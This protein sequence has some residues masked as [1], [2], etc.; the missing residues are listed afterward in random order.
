MFKNRKQ[1]LID[2]KA[3]RNENKTNKDETKL[4]VKE[5]I[6]HNEEQLPAIAYANQEI[7]IV[8]P[9]IEE[10]AETST[11]NVSETNEK[12]SHSEKEWKTAESEQLPT[13][14]FENRDYKLPQINILELPKNH[15]KQ[16]D[17]THIQRIV[18]KLEQ[19]FHS[20]GVKARVTKVHV[21]PSVTKYEVYPEAGVKVSKIVSLHDDL[22]LALA[23]KDIRIEAPIPG[24]SA[25]GIEVPNE[26]PL[27]L[28]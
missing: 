3:H 11:D 9:V 5:E 10:M 7:D 26:E 2:W 12:G 20:F 28:L 22:A 17:K 15:G 14:E 19:T 24:K 21:G 18:R 16:Q 1:S 13:T 25:V 23:A 4:L 27:W 8:E 6:N